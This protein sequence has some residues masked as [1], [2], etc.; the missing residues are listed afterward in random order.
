MIR[1]R[2]R[3]ALGT[4]AA[5]LTVLGAG[6]LGLGAERGGAATVRVAVDSLLLK[7]FRWRSIGP[8]MAFSRSGRFSVSVATPSATS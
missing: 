6:N 1:V 8:E 7:S 5:L 2:T 4:S 3:L